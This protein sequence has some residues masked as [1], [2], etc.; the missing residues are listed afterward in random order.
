M[1]VK[2]KKR[3]EHC[4]CTRNSESSVPIAKELR[5]TNRKRMLKGDDQAEDQL[6]FKTMTPKISQPE[7]PQRSKESNILLLNYVSRE[8]ASHAWRK[9]SHIGAP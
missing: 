6:P 1:A 5:F 4:K 2:R 8:L 3:V 7:W 9:S